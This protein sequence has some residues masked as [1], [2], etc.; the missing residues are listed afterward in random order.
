MINH[1]RDRRSSLFSASVNFDATSLDQGRSQRSNRRA[2]SWSRRSKLLLSMVMVLALVEFFTALFLGT[3]TYSLDRQN[4]I[5]RSDL[6]RSQEELQRAIPE[7]QKLRQDLD[8]LIRGKL[9]HLRQLAYDRVLT[10]DEGYLK[11]ITFTQIINHGVQSYEYKLV[12]QNNTHAV[13]WPEI[14]LRLFN[15]LG[16]EVG[17][18]EVGTTDPNALKAARL[19]IGEVRS[20]SAT[21]QL[22][23]KDTLP[24]YF[25][26]KI[27][28]DANAPVTAD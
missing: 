3:Q 28:G 9:P 15:E 11:N 6:A 7:L 13:L 18:A 20:Y 2:R 8:E 25:T 17:N 1:Y 24:A 23:D 5:L 26:V 14:Q 19:S 21:L 27:L 16:I 10:L 12:V 22:S 4:E